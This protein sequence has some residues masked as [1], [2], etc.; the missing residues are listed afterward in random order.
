MRQG[1]SGSNSQS[2]QKMLNKIRQAERD[3]GTN[4]SGQSGMGK[5]GQSKTG[6]NCP[7]GDC[8]GNGVT[9]GKDLQASDPRGA[10]GGG[11]GLGPR[12]N[13]TGSKN[14]GGVSDQKSKRTGDKR[15]WEDVWSDR[16]PAPRKKIDRVEGKYQ[17][18]GEM[19][20]LPTKT[21]A[22]GG[23]VKTPYYE[24]YESYQKDAEDAVN[25]E[26]VPPAYKQPVK[27]YFESIKP[28]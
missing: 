21:E 27:D 1:T 25:K 19:E 26:T 10:V 7:G 12:N 4:K 22:K 14:G 3:T 6:G 15:R 13:A 28:Q 16:L 11:P 20:Q 18:D 8:S 23:P 5:M 2:L 17:D 9:P 24:V